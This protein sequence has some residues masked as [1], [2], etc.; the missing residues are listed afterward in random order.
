VSTPLH[1]SDEADVGVVGLGGLGSA[2]A[3]ALARR[4]LRV[5]G[6][7]RFALGHERGASHDRSRIIR[8]SYHTPHYVALSAAA[9]DAW[10]EVEAEC[11]EPIVT[12]TGGVDLFPPGAAI[13]HR[14]YLDSLAAGGVDH[15]WLD[16]P[17]VRRRW[18]ALR[19]ADD[20]RAIFSPA[21]GIVPAD[22][23]TATM[24]RL[25]T[26][27]G[28]RLL[29]GEPV[30]SIEIGGGEAVIRTATRSVRCGQVVVAADAWTNHLLG[31]LGAALPLTVTREQLT[32]YR[33]PRQDELCPGRFPVWIWMDD[34]SFYG[35]PRYGGAIEIKAAEDCGGA[36][37]DPDR[38]SFDPDPVAERRLTDFVRR[39]LG[40]ELEPVRSK[41]CLY[42]L[43]PDRDLVV[44]RLA[45][46]P[47]V[48]VT[49]GAAHGFKFAAWFG[50][51]VAELV[52]DGQASADLEPFALAR[53][54]LQA[55]ASRQRWL[56]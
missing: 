28:A 22:R 39:L 8:R 21:T 5:I 16:G 32:Y 54:G 37:V 12:I 47:E 6:L 27:H 29:A 24:A 53:P 52:L 55:S 23:A 34:P 1:R 46:H 14:P 15:E 42:T 48:I 25:A 45:E 26:E 36:E 43:T 4:G 44:D 35:F 2:A 41:T 18:P 30:R 11:G 20:V 51:T 9:Y 3:W 31:P 10:A 19:V 38:R 50:L 40:Q 49:L 17:E 56:V 7:E 33:A 13:D